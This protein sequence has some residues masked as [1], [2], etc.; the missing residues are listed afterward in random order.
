MSRV[1]ETS[2]FYRNETTCSGGD[3]AASGR[4]LWREA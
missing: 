4:E 3:N 1:V 2:N